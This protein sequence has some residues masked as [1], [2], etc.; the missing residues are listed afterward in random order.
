M[1]VTV[2]LVP[3]KVARVQLPDEGSAWQLAQAILGEGV[4]VVTVATDTRRLGS[5]AM[6]MHTNRLTQFAWGENSLHRHQAMCLR[7]GFRCGVVARP[8]FA[9]D[10][11]TPM[12]SCP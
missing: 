1:D 9:R 10:V 8:G 4:A 12:I 11:D 5:N 3:P 7:Q 2:P 6:L